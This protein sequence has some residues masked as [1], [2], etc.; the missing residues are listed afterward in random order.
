MHSS[1]VV[2]Y[3]GHSVR[4]TQERLDHLLAGHNDFGKYEDQIPR[5]I[6]DPDRVVE[7]SWNP[8]ASLYYRAVGVTRRH[9]AKYLCLVVVKANGDRFVATGFVTDRVKAGRVIWDRPT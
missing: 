6:A 8:S 4:L 3:G 2:D 9:K 5:I 7:S 1:E